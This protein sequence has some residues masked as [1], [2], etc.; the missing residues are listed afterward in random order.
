MKVI[1]FGLAKFLDTAERRTTAGMAVGTAHYMSP[2]QCMGED[3]LDG[4]VDVYA[5][6][7][8]TYELFAGD[9]PFVGDAGSIMRKHVG[10]TPRPLQEVASNVPDAV[11]RLLHRMMEKNKDARPTMAEVD[12]EIAA[13]EKKG[14]FKDD[15]S[16]AMPASLSAADAHAPTMLAPTVKKG[17]STASTEKLPTQR[18]PMPRRWIAALLA[19]G[20]LF[21]LLVGAVVAGLSRPQVA[22]PRTCPPQVAATPTPAVA[23]QQKPAPDVSETAAAAESA[24]AE[25]AAKA[26]KGKAGKGKGLRFGDLPATRRRR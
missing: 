1:D 20:A 13:L 21:G 3:H 4:K 25:S 11:C 18:G 19:I 12:A 10:E 23:P 15:G 17:S 26:K 6:G 9:P 7:A 14:E 16:V 22:P 24:S 2:E 5:L 8:L